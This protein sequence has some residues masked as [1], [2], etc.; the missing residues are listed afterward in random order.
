MRCEEVRYMILERT[1]EG[2]FAP[3]AGLADHLHHCPACRDLLARVILVDGALRA[4]PLEAMPGWSVRGMITRAAAAGER[5]EPF[6]PWTFWLPV[7]SLLAGLFWAYVSLIWPAG[8][9]TIRSFSPSVAVLL[10]QFEGWVIAQ[11]EM[12]N[13]VALSIGAGLVFTVLAITL[14]L[15]VGRDRIITRHSH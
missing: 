5:P 4:L 1:L 3:T 12:L 9:D 11:Q 8:P 6:L 15:Y 10:A 13:V 14:G 7:G 2:N